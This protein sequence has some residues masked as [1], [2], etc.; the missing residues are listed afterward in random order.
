MGENKKSFN[1]EQIASLNP[2]ASSS[3]INELEEAIKHKIPEDF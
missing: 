3:D 1:N 2:P